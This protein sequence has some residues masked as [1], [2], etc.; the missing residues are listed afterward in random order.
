MTEKAT[1]QKSRTKIREAVPLAMTVRPV[2]LSPFLFCNRD[3]KGYFYDTTGRAGGCES[4]WCGFFARVMDETTVIERFTEH[5]LR[6]KC[7]SDAKTLEH[8]AALL[9][10]AD[11]KIT[12]RV[13][14]RKPEFVEPLR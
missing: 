3:G 5:D 12:E 1:R 10:H 7:A 14:R 8:A 6:A 4:L 11:S 13:Y 2:Q 9:S